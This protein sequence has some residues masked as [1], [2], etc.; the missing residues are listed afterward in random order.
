MREEFFNEIVNE[1]KNIDEEI[2]QNY[3]YCYYYYHYHYHYYYYYYYYVKYQK[4][5]SFVKDLFKADKNKNDK[6]KYM[7]K[8]NFSKLMEDINIK[9]IPENENPKKVADIVKKILNFNEQQKGRELKILIPNK[10]YILYI[11]LK[12]V[13]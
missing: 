2:F 3:Y 5:S 4:P 6:I 7:N 13:Y 8:I 11:K 9:E 12:N 10:S 1:E